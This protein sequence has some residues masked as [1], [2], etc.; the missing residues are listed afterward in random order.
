MR[1]VEKLIKEELNFSDADYRK[2]KYVGDVIFLEMSKI[3]ILL[4]FFSIVGKTK[5]YIGAII[6]LLFI[7]TNSGGLHFRSYFLCTLVSLGV[8]VLSI[9]ILP[10][11]VTIGK[12]VEI[13]DMFICLVISLFISPVR[14][15]YRDEAS[16]EMI[17]K[18]HEK[19]FVYIL[20]FMVV[21]YIF[22]LNSVTEAMFWTVNLQMIQLI[23]AN[24][25][26]R[27]S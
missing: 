24:M 13:T 17:K 4:L 6:I 23:I 22:P 20:A 10:A 11:C 2:I 26:R 15:V 7:R 12:V 8:L 21:L 25:L 3:I 9:I 19:V 18:C 5:E 1:Y 14:S 27:H 16:K